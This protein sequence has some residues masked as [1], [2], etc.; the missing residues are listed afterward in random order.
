VDEQTEHSVI[1]AA[2]RKMD[3]L[4]LFMGNKKIAASGGSKS[5]SPLKNSPVASG[6]GVNNIWLAL[7]A[8][9]QKSAHSG[10]KS[11]DFTDVVRARRLELPRARLI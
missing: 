1:A 6:N 2:C 11:A 5:H 4:N 8:A 3:G 7:S 10:G 9:K